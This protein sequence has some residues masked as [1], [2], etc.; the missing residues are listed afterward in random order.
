MLNDFYFKVLVEMAIM[1]FGYCF[2]VKFDAYFS[3]SYDKGVR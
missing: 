2:D 1:F 3:V